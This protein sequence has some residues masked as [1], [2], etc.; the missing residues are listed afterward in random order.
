MAAPLIAAAAAVIPTAVDVIGD[1]LRRWI[2]DPEERAQAVQAILASMA[3]SDAGQV[4]I[5]KLEAVGTAI[6]RG[7]RPALGWVGV[8]SAIFT[9]LLQPILEWGSLNFGWIPPPVP[10]TEAMWSIIMGLLGLGAY[11]TYE[12]VQG[13]IPKGK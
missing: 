10:P 11:R 2:P 12:R 3:A 6:Q 8:A 1:L 5:N 9:L 7:W 13:V 4:E